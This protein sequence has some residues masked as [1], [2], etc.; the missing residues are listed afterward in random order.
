MA[1]IRER[2]G[3]Y[4]V[5]YR[6]PNGKEVALD[7][8]GTKNRAETEKRTLENTL[9]RN[10]SFDPRAGRVPLSEWVE[11][12][13]ATKHDVKPKTL[14]GYKG[15]L[16]SRVIPT[17]GDYPLNRIDAEVVDS[18]VASMF[19]DGLSPSRIRQCHQVLSAAL[20]LAV[21]RNVISANPCEGTTLPVEVR[22]EQRF[23]TPDE[24][25]AVAGAMPEHLQAATW[26][27]G[28]AGLRFGE[29]AA[30]LR[31]DIDVLRRRIDISKA[32]TEI[33]G[34]LD[35]AETKNRKSRTVAIPRRLAVI[36][37]DHLTTH[38]ASIVF[39]DTAGGYLRTSNFRG[40]VLRACKA[41]D[42]EPIRTH[43]L[44]H[45]A[46]AMM[47]AVEPDLHLVMQQLGHSS[48]A[49]T[50]DRYGHLLPGRLDQVADKMDAMLDEALP[51]GGNVVAI[52]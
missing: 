45:T 29:M 36:V 3:R 6:K 47:L 5:L 23:L 17:L 25:A 50:V 38:D 15:L 20:K 18:W 26:T 37:N 2:D 40:R 4:Q 12:W 43:D 7:T 34:H 19:G 24:L 22:R 8:F 33:N 49:V 44:R 31:A 30:L 39:P 32:V 48:I 51:D 27:L 11:I 10:A 42:L 41:A 14:H 1:H 52:R 16:R 21:R 46:A 28:L 13:L 35:V 9:D